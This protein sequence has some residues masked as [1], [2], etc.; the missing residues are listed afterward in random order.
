MITGELFFHVSYVFAVFSF[1]TICQY[2]SALFW[3]LMFHVWIIDYLILSASCSIS[4]CV[5]S[6][7][8]ACWLFMIASDFAL[9]MSFRVPDI[10]LRMSEDLLFVAESSSF[11]EVF[12]E[13]SEPEDFNKCFV[14]LLTFFE[15]SSDVQCN[16]SI[17][18]AIS[19]QTAKVNLLFPRPFPL[20]LLFVS[21]CSLVASFHVLGK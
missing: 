2:S 16:L 6:G 9:S 8:S 15:I 4:K 1:R 7:I 21:S 13:L 3:S 14:S 20:C 11:A 10:S 12:S 19:F 5:D 18:S 17:F